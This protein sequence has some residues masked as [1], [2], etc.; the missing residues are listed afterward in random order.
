MFDS[1]TQEYIFTG[2]TMG[3][4]TT[5]YSLLISVAK[6]ESIDDAEEMYDRIRSIMDLDLSIDGT[7]VPN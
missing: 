7:E 3:T 6:F 5:G 2:H 1:T 4:E